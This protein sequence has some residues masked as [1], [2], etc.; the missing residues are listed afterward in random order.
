MGDGGG[1]KKG[2][3]Q[4]KPRHPGQADAEGSGACRD[5]ALKWAGVKLDPGSALRFARDDGKA[6]HHS[7]P[8]T[9]P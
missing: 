9:P 1:G 3:S 8:I 7:F 2:E 6:V 5:P 4:R